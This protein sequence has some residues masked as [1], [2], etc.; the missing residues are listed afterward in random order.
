[1]IRAVFA[2]SIATAA[3]S[4]MHACYDLGPNQVLDSF[5]A[6]LE[7]A[8][9]VMVCN[10]L[11]VVTF[12][13]R[14]FRNGSDL[15]DDVT[16]YLSTQRPRPRAPI[17][18]MSFAGL[19]HSQPITYL[20]AMRR[21]SSL[22]LEEIPSTNAA[23]NNH[24]P[25]GSN[26]SNLSSDDSRESTNDKTVKNDDAVSSPKPVDAAETRPLPPSVQP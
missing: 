23:R 18:F 7:S 12:F 16:V 1:M 8:V 15:D 21:G 24:P 4:A 11:V 6:H 13:Y 2:T 19:S 3:I 10:L 5:T 17:T 25:F 9:T 26:L 22:F 14:R 20:S